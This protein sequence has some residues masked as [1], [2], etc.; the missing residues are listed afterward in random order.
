VPVKK[1]ADAFSIFHVGRSTQN[2]L[3]EPFDRTRSHPAA[4]A[5]S[6]FGASRMELLKATI[7]RELLLMKRNAFMYIFKAVNVRSFFFYMFILIIKVEIRCHQ[8][9]SSVIVAAYCYVVYRDDHI[10]PYQYETR[11]ILWKHLHGG[12]LL[13]SRHNHV[14]W[15]C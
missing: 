1:F 7:D 3:S 10:F 15:F 12:T 4:L 13:C 2:E 5:T 9:D 8:S 11:R 6:K 14:Q